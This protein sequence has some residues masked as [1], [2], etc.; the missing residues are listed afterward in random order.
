MQLTKLSLFSGI[1]GDD[2]AS[3][4]AGIKTVCCVEKDDYCQKVIKKH[5]PHMPIIGDINDA[6][7]EKVKEVSGYKYVDI[8][9]GGDPCQPRSVAGKRLGKAD[10]RDLWKVM[11][12]TICEFKPSWVVNENPTGRLT[13][14]FGEVLSD[15][16][17]IGYETQSFVIP[18]CAV[19]A[20][21]RRERL[22]VIAYSDSIGRQRRIKRMSAV[23]EDRYVKTDSITKALRGSGI[24]NDIS[25]PDI[26]RAVDG[27]PYRTHRLK[28]L[29]NAVV[30][31][32]IY[33]IYKAIVDVEDSLL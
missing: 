18:A 30:P 25:T 12:K 9:G 32:Q 4:W 28:S 29:G 19:N 17:S 23:F 26:C 6:T 13:M 33:P 16:E 24:G 10:D 7:K 22:F 15:L 5:Y 14:D 31:Q 21:H 2:L 1:L 20:L 27:I 3:E 11:F 8:I